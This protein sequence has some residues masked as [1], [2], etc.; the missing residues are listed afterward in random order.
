MIEARPE[1]EELELVRRA[2][3]GD[4]AA[5]GELVRRHRGAVYQFARRLTKDA[6]LAEDV[7]QD[8]FIAAVTHLADWRGEGSFKGWLF[9]IARK[10][11]LRTRRRRAGEP[12]RHEPIDSL[13]ELGARAGWG[14]PSD[15]EVLAGQR[16]ERALFEAALATLDEDDREILLL[17]DVEGLTG[18]ETARAIG[19]AVPAMKS[20]LHRARLRLV[21][22]LR[23]GGLS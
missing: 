13:V 16:E 15:P 23:T 21:A 18:D 19:L 11:V 7:L 5:L 10:A 6:T 3:S 9:A 14:A 20:R 17:R 1:E 4:A 8:T 12:D 22:A 2:S